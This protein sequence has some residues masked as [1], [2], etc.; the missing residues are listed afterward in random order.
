MLIGVSIYALVLL[1]LLFFVSSSGFLN[2]YFP[3]WYTWS[4]SHRLSFK[5]NAQRTLHWMTASKNKGYWESI[6]PVKVGTLA[7]AVVVLVVVAAAVIVVIIVVA[8][9][10]VVVVVVVVVDSD[11]NVQTVSDDTLAFSPFLHIHNMNNR[12]SISVQ[13]LS[14]GKTRRRKGS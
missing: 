7:A 12:F 13:V 1:L 6:Q 11:R 3:D 14:H 2:A 9:V 4:P 8:M 5:Y 10:A